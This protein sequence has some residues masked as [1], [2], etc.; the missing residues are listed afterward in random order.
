MDRICG[1]CAGYARPY[2]PSR[3]WMVTGFPRNT[4]DVHDAVCPRPRPCYLGVLMDVEARAALR[5]LAAP[6][7][8]CWAVCP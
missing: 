3:M 2:N 7:G 6:K 5:L 8:W 4:R 1:V